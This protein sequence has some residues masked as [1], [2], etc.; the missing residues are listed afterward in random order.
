MNI[1]IV[2]VSTCELHSCM[3]VV[4]YGVGHVNEHMCVFQFIEQKRKKP[5]IQT[6]KER[7]HSRQELSPHVYC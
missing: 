2:F 1:N 4:C 6:K 7:I 3:F 5:R